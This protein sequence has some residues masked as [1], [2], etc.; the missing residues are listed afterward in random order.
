MTFSDS[1]IF[2]AA[3]ENDVYAI[4]EMIAA[5]MSVNS[6][7][8]IGQGGLHVA[9]IWGSTAAVKVLLSGNANPNVQNQIGIII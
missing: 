3:K 7:N 2:A 4:T 1:A 8:Q 9:A 6:T 5:G